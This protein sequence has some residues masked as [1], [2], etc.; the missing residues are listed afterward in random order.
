[1]TFRYVSNFLTLLKTLK[2]VPSKLENES[3]KYLSVD[4]ALADVAHF[5]TELK[6]VPKYEN[7]S[8]VVIGG[9]Y[10]ATMAIWFRQKYPHLTVG[11]WASSAPVLGKMDFTEYKEIVGQSIATVAGNHCVEV[12][13]E[14]IARAEELIEN[15]Q[16]KE[17]KKTFHLCDDFDHDD[18][19]NIWTLFG[20]VSNVFAGAVQK[21]L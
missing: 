14:G 12:I 2:N 17:F 20:R 9:S 4:Q 6:S 15:G 7:S 10:S 11:A 1:M 16:F 18:I 5:I 8:V 13:R 3:L 19:Y 21:Y